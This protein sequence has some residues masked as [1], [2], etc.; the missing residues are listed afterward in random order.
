MYGQVGVDDA[1]S[2]VGAH[3]AAAHRV[4]DVGDTEDFGF[5]IADL[6]ASVDALKTKRLNF[7][8]S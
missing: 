3:A 5:G 1:L 4:V 2:R 7:S 8:R 6:G